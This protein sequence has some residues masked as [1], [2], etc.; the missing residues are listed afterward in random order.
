MKCGISLELYA[1]E[2]EL[3]AKIPRSTLNQ[4]SSLIL[5]RDGCWLWGNSFQ[6]KDVE[7]AKRKTP[8]QAVG[9][10]QNFKFLIKSWLALAMAMLVAYWRP[11]AK[12]CLPALNFKSHCRPRRHNLNLREVSFH[13]RK[14]HCQWCSNDH[15]QR[16]WLTLQL[17][18][19]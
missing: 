14:L 8:V 10:S 19:C 2:V 11:H 17:L 9:I 1:S 7:R 16:N 12:F 3:D 13:K 18:T 15:K 5:I 6:F 4:W